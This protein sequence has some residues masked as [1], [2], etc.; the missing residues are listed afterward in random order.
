MNYYENVDD[1][2]LEGEVFKNIEEYNGDYQVSNFGRIKSFKKWNGTDVRILKQI[3][4]KDG[5]LQVGLS[6]NGKSETKKVHKLEFKTFNSYKLKENEYKEFSSFIIHHIDENPSNNLLDNFQLMTNSEHHSLHISG[7][8]NPR[9]MLGKHHSEETKQLM[10]KNNS[11]ENNPNYGKKCPEHSKRM[12]GENH[13]RSI[14]KEQDVIEIRKLSDEGVLTQKEIAE[15]FGVTQASISAIKNR[16][17][18]K[19]I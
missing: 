9:G 19:H 6:K 18:W 11:G 2:F 7:E 1:L 12:S 8:K 3:K 14:L 17:I 16:R 4:D 10:S 13:P 15:I 5:Y